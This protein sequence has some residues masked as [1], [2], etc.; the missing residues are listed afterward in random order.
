MEIM[1][2]FFILVIVMGMVVTGIN[3]IM[4]S[5]NELQEKSAR[6]AQLQVA[7]AIMAQDLSQVVDRPIRDIDGGT[8][9][10]IIVDTPN[11]I[12]IE[13]TRSGF[14]NPAA[15]MQRSQFIRV[16]YR[17][18]GETLQRL[19]WQVLDRAPNSTPESRVLLPDV[20]GLAI[21]ALNENNEW[22]DISLGRTLNV[23]RAFA[24]DLRFADDRSLRRVILVGAGGVS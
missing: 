19:I 14:V 3:T 5:Q 13:F 17:W 12:A 9:P 2:A 18:D 11:Q 20:K 10:A 21:Y 7:V 8:L 23:P 16:A 22:V 4:R 24:F 15:L 1:I 6:L